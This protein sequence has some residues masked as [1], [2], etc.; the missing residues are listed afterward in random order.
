MCAINTCVEESNCHAAAVLVGEPD[1]RALAELGG[2]QQTRAERS[3]I[4]GANGIDAGNVCGALDES[5]A[6]RVERRRETV[7]GA[8]VTE[9][10]LDD[11]PLEAQAGNEQLL[12]GERRVRPA[13]FVLARRQAS[14]TAHAV[15]QRRCFE[16]DD[17]SL[18]DCDPGP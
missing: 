17:D 18:A 5:N 2:R 6:A 14:G 1:V 13:P 12:R 16:H 15:R 10:G 11:N 4:G 3:G 9:L 8:R 7:D